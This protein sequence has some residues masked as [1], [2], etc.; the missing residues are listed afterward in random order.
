V[1]QLFTPFFTT[2]PIGVGTGLGLSICHQLVTALGGEIEVD[3]EL[4]V[5]TT[6]AILLP[7]VAQAAHAERVTAAPA[8][9]SRRGR[10]LVVDDE[11][12]VATTF[13]RALG[14]AHDV[15]ATD[16][17]DAARRIAAGQ[18]FDVILCDLMMP[19]ITGMD[20]YEELSRVAPDQAARMVFITGGA[21]TA[22]GSAFL[23]QTKNPYLEKPVDLE[24]LRALVTA[25]IRSID[26]GAGT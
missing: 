12:M 20:L 2:K 1:A 18:E 14:R 21:F 25:T 22:Q 6:F 8:V 23:E 26:E 10:V 3:T 9:A 19:D 17:T 13:S 4:G 24:A 7:A 5:G 16:P 11:E 15:I